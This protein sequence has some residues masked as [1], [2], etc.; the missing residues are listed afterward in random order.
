M[1][2]LRNLVTSL[3]EHEQI[4]TT[5]PKARDTAR[6]AEKIISLGKKN[7]NAS[8]SRVSSFLL[9]PDILPKVFGTFAQ[10]YATRPGGYTR[11]HKFGNRKGDN[12]P[13]AIVEL[14]DN[15]RDLRWELTSR[16]VGW[17]VMRR[18]LMGTKVSKLVND[19]H[20]DMQQILKTEAQAPY[21]SHGLLRE[22]T[23]WNLQKLLKYRDT[24]ALP[25]MAEKASDHM[26]QLLATPVALKSL[27]E[28]TKAKVPRKPHPRLHAGQLV[29]GENRSV[30][31]MARGKLGSAISPKGPL[32]T[33]KSVFGSKYKTL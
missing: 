25:A 13:E 18:R 31:Q 26:D 22:K 23:R 1:L 28:E 8:Q 15:P 12:A 6:L 16:A 20:G 32:L 24:N 4:R 21:K 3:F 33:M 9:K 17:D 11:I 10:R 19:P 30:L 7:T 27:Y 2:M 5:L 14:V 29:P